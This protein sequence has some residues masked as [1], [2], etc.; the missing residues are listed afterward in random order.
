MREGPGSPKGESWESKSLVLPLLSRD[1]PK[2]IGDS[3]RDDGESL[4]WEWGPTKG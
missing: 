2:P 1:N 4:P 3:E